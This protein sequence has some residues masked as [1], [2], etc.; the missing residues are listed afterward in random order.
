MTSPKKNK[1]EI[2]RSENDE[3]EKGLFRKGKQC[4]GQV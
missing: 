1:L 4:K 3:T 2:D